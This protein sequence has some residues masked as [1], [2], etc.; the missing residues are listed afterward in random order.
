M[1]EPLCLPRT[2]DAWESMR[3]YIEVFISKYCGAIQGHVNITDVPHD[4]SRAKITFLYI[5]NKTGEHCRGNGEIT[6]CW[7]EQGGTYVRLVID[8]VSNGADW[9]IYF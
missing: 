8:G 9:R 5:N 3:C 7:N 4:D 6:A 1:A 2:Q